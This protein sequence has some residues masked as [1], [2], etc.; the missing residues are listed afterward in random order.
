MSLPSAGR[1]VN[2]KTSME[3]RTYTI[4]NRFGLRAILLGMAIFAI[5]F[6]VGLAV[7][8][9]LRIVAPLLSFVVLV[10]LAQMVFGWIPRI[11]SALV[12][13]FVFPA[14][15]YIDPLFDGEFH[16]QRVSAVD[17]FWLI[18]CGLLAGYFGGVLLA[19][20]FLLAD[21][22]GKKREHVYSV[23]RQFGTGTMLLATTLFAMLFA[24]LNWAQVRP[25]QL[26]FYA[27]FVATV[28]AA[29][30]FLPRTPRW[31]SMAAGAFF[32]PLSILSY[33]RLGRQWRLSTDDS[34][35]MLATALIGL[36]IGYLG[37][38]LI[39]GIFLISD[40]VMTFFTRG[41]ISIHPGPAV[42]DE[43]MEGGTLTLLAQRASASRRKLS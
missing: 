4:P 18:T 35:S 6:T 24:F 29:Q 5:V 40:Y 14:S 41:R 8:A 11:A 32:L 17:L 33:D 23:P 12:G 20:V 39:A 10:C 15:A 34:L 30:M 31:A 22:F 42:V 9:E 21:C 16:L 28:C 25:Y 19:G 2:G 3:E 27:S 7:E 13:G 43:P 37:G 38:T 36:V 1:R 26:F